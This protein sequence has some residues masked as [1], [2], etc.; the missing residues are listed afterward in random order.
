MAHHRM[1]CEPLAGNFADYSDCVSM[2]CCARF[3]SHFLPGAAVSDKLRFTRVKTSHGCAAT[4]ND[5]SC[6]G[7]NTAASAA[8][9]TGEIEMKTTIAAVTFVLLATTAATADTYRID[10]IGSN[11]PLP[12]NYPVFAPAAPVLAAPVLTAPVVTT[13]PVAAAPAVSAPVATVAQAPIIV[14]SPVMA[15]APMVVQSPIMAPA[16]VMA[17]PVMTYYAPAPVYYAPVRARTIIRPWGARTV[18][19]Y[20]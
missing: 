15:P 7:L 10:S 2:L 19:R 4:F 20:W 16:P 3:S 13:P 9:R 8:E 14:Q 17:A 11:A 12:I 1:A 18:Y 6:A 5:T